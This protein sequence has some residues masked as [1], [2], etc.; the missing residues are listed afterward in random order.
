MKRARAASQPKARRAGLVVRELPDE[1][2][3]YDMENHKAHCLNKAA[4]LV[5]ALCNGKRS[6]REI[7]EQLE[8]KGPFTEDVVRLALD[9]LGRFSLLEERFGL[10]LGAPQMSRRELGRKLGLTS[11]AALPFVLSILAPTAAAAA[12]C[13]P[14]GSPC[15]TNERCCSGICVGGTCA[16]LGKDSTCTLDA[17]CCSNRCGSALNKCLP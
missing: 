12:T 1:V 14:V 13:G 17:Q 11:V 6:V 3:V 16:C 10:P 8:A 9:Q 2:L 7:A 15:A 5:W 4:A